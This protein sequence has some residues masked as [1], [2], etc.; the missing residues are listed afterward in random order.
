MNAETSSFDP[1]IFLDAT[2]SEASVRRPPL[3]SGLVLT[4]TI[5]DLAMRKVQGK[6]DT[7]K[8]YLFMDVKIVVQVPL[9]FQAEGPTKQPPEVTYTDGVSLDTTPSGGLDMSPGKNGKLRRYRESLDMNTPGV[10]F[11]PRQMIGRQIGVKLKHEPFEGEM[12][13]RV[14]SVVKAS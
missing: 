10:P 8:E 14:D 4:G 6:K 11:A 1:S 5:M 3:P 12:Y 2:T 9:E 7:T 13:D